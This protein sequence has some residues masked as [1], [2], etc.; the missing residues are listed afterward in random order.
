[1]ACICQ[2]VVSFDLDLV[3]SVV[4]PHF[5]LI[6][7]PEVSYKEFICLNETICSSRL[8]FFTFLMRKLYSVKEFYSTNFIIF[9]TFRE[10]GSLFPYARDT[11]LLYCCFI[12]QACDVVVTLGE[13]G[14]LLL[15]EVVSLSL[16]FPEVDLN[17]GL[18]HPF[19]LR[20]LPL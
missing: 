9:S 16:M 13:F 1:M 8:A 7:I 18:L 5:D 19:A 3:F 4:V 2:K 15:C 12:R 17:I 11:S 10:E 6:S 20:M 14:M